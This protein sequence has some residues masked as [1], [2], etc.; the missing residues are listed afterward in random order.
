M[1][2]RKWTHIVPSSYHPAKN[3][4]NIRSIIKKTKYRN[5]LTVNIILSPLNLNAGKYWKYVCPFTS[6]IVRLFVCVWVCRWLW[7]LLLLLLFAS[8]SS[9]LSMKLLCTI[10]LPLCV[11]NFNLLFFIT[12]KT[13][14]V[15]LNFL[16]YFAQV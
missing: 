15:S 10:I 12:P 3:Y 6:N 5:K 11:Y 4:N 7:W 14:H 16:F 9:L 8:F 2:C 1:N 13:P